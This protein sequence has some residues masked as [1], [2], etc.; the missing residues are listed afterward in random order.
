MTDTSRPSASVFACLGALMNRLDLYDLDVRIGR[1][2]LHVSNPRA[3]GCCEGA[4]EPADMI[5]CRS[6]A[7]DGGRL[8]FFTSWGEPI[9]EAERVVDAAVIIAGRFAGA[10][11]LE[12]R[13]A[14]GPRGRV[15]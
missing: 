5:T 2:G 15:R 7:E 14:P 9:A 10:R 13:R 3:D 12:A 8:W 6:R 1:C 11:R 4:P